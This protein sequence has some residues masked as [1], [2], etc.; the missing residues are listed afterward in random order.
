MTDRTLQQAN[1]AFKQHQWHTAATLYEQ[2]YEREK[3]AKINHLLVK[4]LFEDQQYVTAKAVM[5]DDWN[6]YLV[7]T[8]HFELMVQ[9]LLK[10][11]QLLMVHVLMA[12]TGATSSKIETLLTQAE[13]QCRQQSHFQADYQAFY[14]LS[15]HGL[16]QQR[17]AFE[18]GKQLPLAEWLTATKALLTDPFVKP[19]IRVSLIQL[20][21]RL[22]ISETV[23]FRWLDD[24]TYQLKPALLTPFE[25]LPIVAQLSQ[26]LSD[27]I[28]Q[29]DPIT[30]QLYQ[31]S[32]QLQ[33]TLLYPFIDRAISDST[34]WIDRLVYGESN[35]GGKLP[36]QFSVAWWQQKLALIMSEMTGA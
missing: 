16:Q 9:V 4:S 19:V 2:V 27:E 24:Q 22:K 21:Q 17:Q 6:S 31:D 11:R 18:A 34:E 3:S 8:D 25:Q 33:L 29:N 32:L 13:G 36:A 5:A 7:D 23:K 12:T 26:Q 14:Q 30:Q 28:A 35:V 20:M 15:A 1:A 10:N